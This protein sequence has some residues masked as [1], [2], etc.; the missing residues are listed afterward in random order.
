MNPEL[1]A[2]F[3]TELSALA[4]EIHTYFRE[5]PRL[6]AEGEDGR[7]VVVKGADLFGVWD[8]YSDAIQLGRERFPDGGFLAQEIDSRFLDAFG[9]FFNAPA[10]SGAA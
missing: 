6:L 8:T 4:T 3:P 10:A 7:V 5:L 9:S 1:P 2:G